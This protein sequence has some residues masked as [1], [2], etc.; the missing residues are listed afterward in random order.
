MVYETT[1]EW[2][3][4]SLILCA[5]GSLCFGSLVVILD[6][7][8]H[9]CWVDRRNELANRG[10]G[11][12]MVLATVCGSR[13]ARPPFSSLS[14]LSVSPSLFSLLSHPPQS[15]FSALL[16]PHESNP[17][18]SFLLCVI[19]IVHSKCRVSLRL[20]R[21]LLRLL[22]L[23]PPPLRRPP[24]ARLFLLMWSLR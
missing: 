7:H 13:F 14:N 11:L 3:T 23:L 20:C 10:V 17:C 2:P 16:F 22:R 18:C 4:I 21:R 9:Y 8:V 12:E 24:L 6:S 1:L 5:C 19:L 15:L